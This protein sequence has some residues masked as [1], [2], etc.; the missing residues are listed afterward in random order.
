MTMYHTGHAGRLL[1]AVLCAF[2]AVAGTEHGR[3]A[4]GTPA[5]A[6]TVEAPTWTP[7]EAGFEKDEAVRRSG[8]FAVRCVNASATEKRGAELVFHLNQTRPVPVVITGWSRAQ[9]VDGSANS[10]YSLYADLEYDD[11]SPVWGYAAAFDTGTH[12]WQ[13]RRLTITPD[14]PIKTL[15]VYGLLRG[16]AG[17][18]WFD[19]FS[20]TPL[21]GSKIFDS[22]ALPPPT[23]PAGVS[24]GWFVRDVAAGGALVPLAP[25][26][27]SADGLSLAA[28]KL[29]KNGRLLRTS[30]HS[31]GKRTRAVT[32]YYVERFDAPMPIWWRTIHEQA[33]LTDTEGT[34]AVTAGDVGATGTQTKYPFGC[35]TGG[36]GGRA[37]AI[38][39][40]LGPRIARI[41]YHPAAHLLYIALDLA[42]MPDR[43]PAPVA[44]ARYNVSTEWGFRDAARTYY[45]LFPAYYEKRTKVEGIWMPFTDP[46]HVK[47][48]QDFG[49]A[50]HE[51]DNSVATDDALGILSFRYAEPMSFWMN[52]PPAESRDYDTALTRLKRLA[53]G[54]QPARDAE[55]LHQAKATLASGSKDASG[56]FN[57][58][59][60][61]AP[62]ANG[63]VWT[64]NP[65]PKMPGEWNKARVNYDLADA[66][67]RYGKGAKGVL[68]G[69]YLDSMESM[70]NVLDYNPE[71]LRASTAPPTFATESF[72]PVLP[73]WFSVWEYADWLRTDLRKRGKL[74]MGNSTPWT[75]YAFSPLLD[76]AGT[77]T[78]WLEGDG[79]L[80]PEND[81]MM[82]W[83]RTLSGR[84]P[85]LLLMNTDFDK[86][87]HDYVERYF[88]RCLFYGIF[89]S[90]FSVNAADKPYWENPKWYDRDRDLFKKNIPTIQ[91]LSTAGW[92]PI[93]YARSS[94]PAVYIERYGNR[95]LTLLNSSSA[96]A[97]TTLQ[98]V[99]AQWPSASKG[100]P[101]ESVDALTGEKIAAT[102]R[103]GAL[104]LSVTLQPG[105]TRVLQ[106]A[107]A[108]AKTTAGH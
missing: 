15:Q 39:P 98:L 29:D 82:S 59:Y 68:D 36:N 24:S 89:P 19:D 41:G 40:D 62:W 81:A 14:R 86:F 96:P 25:G 16:H 30:L 54:E 9:G 97:T 101:V 74:L 61:N 20:V 45:A 84:K 102:N 51:G 57:V 13:R 88:Q 55:E 18:A 83:R 100:I 99:A 78:N 107:P 75:I 60:Q 50:W 103:A 44:V 71:S 12:D 1:L 42:L 105:E 28:V 94:N 17:T 34:N 67:R 104:S 2:A 92:E 66:D 53:S 95:Y 90:F 35:V 76:A 80:H 23:L 73:T 22:Q 108:A 77:E 26:G 69:E 46:S 37:L 49:I 6:H 43:G 31:D 65:N 64:L 52:M 72:R 5:A 93:P 27:K 70:A 10:D 11:G 56:R 85:Y 32:L 33:P 47:N 91:K 106:F 38:P 7:F 58:Q 63:A 8:A 3:L 21:A 87:T 48:V 4:F 79:S